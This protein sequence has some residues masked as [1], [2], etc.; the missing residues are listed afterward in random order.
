MINF[1]SSQAELDARYREKLRIKAEADA[2]EAARLAEAKRQK[3]QKDELRTNKKMYEMFDMLWQWSIADMYVYTYG[4]VNQFE[5]FFPVLP[6]GL[7]DGSTTQNQ[8]Y[9]I[10]Y[11]NRG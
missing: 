10:D 1:C 3:D 7:I 2:K 5:V 11:E 6:G 4:C 9:I 8:P